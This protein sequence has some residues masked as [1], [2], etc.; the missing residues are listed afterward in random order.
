MK[1]KIEVPHISSELIEYLEKMYPDQVPLP[2]MGDRDIWIKVGQVEVVRKLKFE[3]E[4]AAKK[5]LTN[6]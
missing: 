6:S 5:A 1:T 2:S 4:R 3:Q